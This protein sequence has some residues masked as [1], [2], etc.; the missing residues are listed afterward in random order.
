VSIKAE[1]MEMP[2]SDNKILQKEF[3]EIKIVDVDDDNPFGF[4]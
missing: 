3:D 1:A 2:F 4:V